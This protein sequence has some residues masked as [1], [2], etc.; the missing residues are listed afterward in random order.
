MLRL[1]PGPPATFLITAPT[2]AGKRSQRTIM[3][4]MCRR[5]ILKP[6]PDTPTNS[7]T[8]LRGYPYGRFQHSDVTCVEQTFALAVTSPVEI[9]PGVT[10]PRP[11]GVEVRRVRRDTSRSP[12]V[13]N[14]CCANG[15]LT[16]TRQLVTSLQ[17]STSSMAR[18]ESLRARAGLRNRR[19]RDWSDCGWCDVAARG[20]RPPLR[21]LRRAR[22]HLRGWRS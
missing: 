9:A 6:V 10:R 7:Y 11:A 4:T 15:S 5:E 12:R 18:Q 8:L 1:A 22:W 3:R 21:P 14:A 2:L 20:S 17:L 16:V 19:A 13:E